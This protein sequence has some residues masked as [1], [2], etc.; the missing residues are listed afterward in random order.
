M[1]FGGGSGS[2]TKASSV[3]QAGGGAE[4]AP[5]GEVHPD[6]EVCG[7][8]IEALQSRRPRP[9]GRPRPGETHSRTFRARASPTWSSRPS[10]VAEG[11]LKTL[12]PSGD[13]VRLERF[14]HRGEES[15][16]H[17]GAAGHHRDGR[18]TASQRPQ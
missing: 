16:Q 6:G 18:G 12:S 8:E 11:A 13:D 2:Y 5:G 9:P 3:V 7:E 17:R 15:R 14:L 4:A 1:F 10:A